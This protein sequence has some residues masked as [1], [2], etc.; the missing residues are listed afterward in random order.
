M[1]N[2]ISSIYSTSTQCLLSKGSELVTH[3][4]SAEENR[5]EGFSCPLNI[6]PFLS[7][8]LCLNATLLLP[9]S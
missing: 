3:S 6:K 8:P 5:K 7:Y 4:L 1:K 9:P 2:T